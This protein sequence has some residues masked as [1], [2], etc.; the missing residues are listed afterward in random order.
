MI[1]TYNPT[2]TVEAEIERSNHSRQLQFEP[3]ANG[4][5]S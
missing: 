2:T 5:N 1:G 4:G 3:A